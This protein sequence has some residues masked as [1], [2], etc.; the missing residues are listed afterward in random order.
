MKRDFYFSA[1]TKLE[2]FPFSRFLLRQNE[3]NVLNAELS[4]SGTFENPYLSAKLIDSSVLL[5]GSNLTA[6]AEASLIENTFTIS[7]ADIS[8]K[9]FQIDSVSSNIDFETFSGTASLKAKAHAGEKKLKRESNLY[10][11]IF[12]KI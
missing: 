4:A 3:S 7:S 6:S 5:G 11:Q 1:G 8:W 2:A 9:N 10:F 12:L